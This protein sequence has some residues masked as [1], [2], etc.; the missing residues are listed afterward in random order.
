M[1]T[2]EEPRGRLLKLDKRNFTSRNRWPFF[3]ARPFPI[4]QMARTR[5]GTPETSERHKRKQAFS[6]TM[7]HPAWSSVAK[8]RADGRRKNNASDGSS[9][10]WQ[11]SKKMSNTHPSRSL[12]SFLSLYDDSM[13]RAQRRIKAFWALCPLIN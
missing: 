6:H 8:W 3:F 4:L 5:D 13:L 10:G 2:S 11:R 1:I 7:G 12:S 9:S